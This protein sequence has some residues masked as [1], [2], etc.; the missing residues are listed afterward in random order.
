V[1]TQPR[2][3]VGGILAQIMVTV[4][5]NFVNTLTYTYIIYLIY[6]SAI[7]NLNKK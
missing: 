5:E 6:T 3:D 7:V 2:R 4:T 1:S